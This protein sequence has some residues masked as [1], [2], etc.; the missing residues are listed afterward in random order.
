MKDLIGNVVTLREGYESCKAVV[1]GVQDDYYIVHGV[2][3]SGHLSR[4]DLYTL[5]ELKRGV[6]VYRPYE[7][8]DKY[9]GTLLK[10]LEL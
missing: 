5:E 1:T 6:P 9:S 10:E 7:G 4:P 2:M 3:W 8:D